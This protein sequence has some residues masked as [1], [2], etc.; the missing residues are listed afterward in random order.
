MVDGVPRYA[1]IS[2]LGIGSYNGILPTIDGL[3]GF[4]PLVTRNGFRSDTNYLAVTVPPGSSARMLHID[5]VQAS[6]LPERVCRSG[7]AKN[8]LFHRCK[9]LGATLLSGSRQCCGSVPLTAFGQSAAARNSRGS[10]LQYSEDQASL[11]HLSFRRLSE[12]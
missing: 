11:R 3:H 8:R 1:A 12:A 6:G 5:G 7:F 2:I 10:R 4:W 9:L